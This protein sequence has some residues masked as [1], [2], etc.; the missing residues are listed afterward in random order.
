MGKRWILLIRAGGNVEQGEEVCRKVSSRGQEGAGRWLL[1]VLEGGEAAIPLRDDYTETEAIREFYTI[2]GFIAAFSDN[3]NPEKYVIL[4]KNPRCN[5]KMKIPKLKRSIIVTCPH[6]G[7]EIK[8]LSP[9]ESAHNVWSGSFSNRN[10]ND[11][12]GD[13]FGTKNV[14]QRK[15]LKQAFVTRNA[16]SN[17]TQQQKS[18]LKNNNSQ[19]TRQIT[20]YR[21]THVHKEFSFRGI[22]NTLKDSVQVNFSMDGK[23]AGS[24]GQ[25]PLEIPM[26]SREHIIKCGL[27]DSYRI[28]AGDKDYK[29]YYFNNNL[30]IGF[31]PD[32]FREQLVEFMVNLFRGRGIKD[33]LLDSNNST[34]SVSVY[35]LPDYVRLSFPLKNTKGLKE[36]ATGT[37]E[38]K[39]SF[40]EIGLMVPHVDSLPDGYFGFIEDYVL[41]AID[42][43]EE[44][45]MERNGN[46][47]KIR[48][49]HRLY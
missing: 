16:Q 41:S 10:T 47:I 8:V 44:A 34:N 19:P 6:C 12:S 33:R 49:T 9:S 3:T 11:K 23:S 5:Q 27:L 25:D 1:N 20:I 48:K 43:D 29:A 45:D 22:H 15:N 46:S 24:L 18:Q 30:M 36:W 42:H 13:A 40:Q 14:G 26:D 35:I 17:S 28:P 4:C 32:P 38:E 7:N 2:P 37:R 31:D 39:I 21:L